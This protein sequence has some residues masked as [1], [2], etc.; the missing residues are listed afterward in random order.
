M[1]LAP[2]PTAINIIP[3]TRPSSPATEASASTPPNT[4]T[5]AAAAAPAPATDGR[6]DDDR[7]FQQVAGDKIERMSEWLRQHADIF[8]HLSAGL[9]KH[10]S[11]N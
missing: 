6:D 1:S 7:T 10:V 11:F 4:A 5:A 3:P 8:T 9:L 2:P